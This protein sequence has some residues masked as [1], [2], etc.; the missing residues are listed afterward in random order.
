MNEVVANMTK[1]PGR[2]LGKDIELQLNYSPHPARVQADAGMMEQVLLNLAVN[3]HDAMPRGGL[4]A[5]KI[6]ALRSF[7]RDGGASTRC[8]DSQ[9]RAK[10]LL[11]LAPWRINISPCLK[12]Y[13][14]RSV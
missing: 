12:A 11:V 4:L 1:M 10:F 8:A 14:C 9:S 2:I 7:G 3:S 13:I 5:I 6:S